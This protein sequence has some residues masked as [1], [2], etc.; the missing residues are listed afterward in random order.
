MTETNYK[1]KAEERLEQLHAE[2]EKGQAIITEREGMRLHLTQLDAQ[3]PVLQQRMVR[4][5]AAIQVLEEIL[6]LPLNDAN[7]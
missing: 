2:L 4:I 1:Q 7:N 5:R 3:A 6:V